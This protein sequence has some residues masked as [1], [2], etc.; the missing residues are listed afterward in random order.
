MDGIRNCGRPLGVKYAVLAG[1]LDSRCH[2]VAIH[3]R[4]I[5]VHVV[6]CDPE[7]KARGWSPMACP[8]MRTLRGRRPSRCGPRGGYD[9]D[10]GDGCCS[11]FGCCT[12]Q[13]LALKRY[14]P[15]VQA[16]PVVV[17]AC[18]A[19]GFWPGR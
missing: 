8:I 19:K 12:E 3:V 13:G 4:Q 15:E 2:E 1:H 9:V 18:L 6:W 14:A 11:G 16:L 17:R 5:E 7:A 10:P